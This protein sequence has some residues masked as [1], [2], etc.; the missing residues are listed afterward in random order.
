MC[1]DRSQPSFARPALV[2]LIVAIAALFVGPGGEVLKTI[3]S[4]GWCGWKFG[5]DAK[6]GTGGLV[7]EKTAFY[8]LL[9][10]QRPKEI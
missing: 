9:L 10:P 4:G 1:F 7:F 2:V 3:H 8:N 5:E 6:G